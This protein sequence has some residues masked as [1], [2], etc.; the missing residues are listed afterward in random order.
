MKLDIRCQTTGL[1]AYATREHC[2]ESISD[3]V[4]ETAYECRHCHFFHPGPREM[5]PVNGKRGYLSRRACER[6][7]EKAWTDPT[8]KGHLHGRMP[9]R[10]YLC[11]HCQRWHMSTH[12]RTF[13]ELHGHVDPALTPTDA[14]ATMVA[15]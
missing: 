5:C 15:S 3:K 9:R 11:P 7:I 14:N 2:Q 1:L 6:D 4:H 10:A 8:W 12:S 13:E